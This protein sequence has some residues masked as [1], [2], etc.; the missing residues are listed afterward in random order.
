MFALAAACGHAAPFAGNDV[1]GIA[2]DAIAAV[3]APK[4][5]TAHDAELEAAP[6]VGGYP[7]EPYG[8][9]VGD[10]FPPLVLDGYPEG[11]PAWSKVSL[12]DLFDPDGKKG[13][14]AILL[15]VAAEWCGACKAEAT[16]VPGAYSMTYRPRGARFVTA[17]VQN[18]STGAATQSTATAW[19]DAYGI[20]YAVAIDPMLDTL[21][22]NAG[23]LPL[24]Y[25]YVIDPRTM[26]VVKILTSEQSPPTIPAVDALLTKNGG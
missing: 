23:V 7:A 9:N 3:D 20:P 10:T 21:P 1:D 2:P 12:R 26:R 11:D 16:W 5:D 24:P 4:P 14:R 18:A 25:S 19:R 17:L 15:V 13:I 22:M 8:K 6:I